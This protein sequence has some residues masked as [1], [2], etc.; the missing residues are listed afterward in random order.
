MSE[1]AKMYNLENIILKLK[2]KKQINKKYLKWYFLKLFT[3]KIFI[4]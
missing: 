3:F 1:L 4:N 2:K